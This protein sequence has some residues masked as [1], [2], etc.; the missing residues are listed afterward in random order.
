MALGRKT[1]GRKKGTPNKVTRDM[2]A[3]FK[4]IVDG[5]MDDLPA[6]IDEARYGIEIEKQMPDGTTVVGRMNADPA[7]AAG[8][9]LQA[10]EFCVPK[11]ARTEQTLEHATDDELLGEIRRRAALNQPA[12]A[13]V[14]HG[15]A[16][17]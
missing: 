8:L 2:R 5:K 12:P 1:G 15:P 9:V 7:K 14:D 3:M 6:M 16:I 11:L 13:P 10:A 17:Q 4:S